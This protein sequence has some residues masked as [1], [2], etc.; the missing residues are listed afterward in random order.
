MFYPTAR[1]FPFMVTALL[2]LFLNAVCV[3]CGSA[4]PSTL[5]PTPTS[6]LPSPA[7]TTPSF[8]C[9]QPNLVSGKPTFAGLAYSPYHTGQDPTVRV[10]NSSTT[11]ISP[12]LQ[13]I[14]ADMPT[15]ASLTN[16]IRIYSSTGPA[17]MIIKAAQANHICVALGLSLSADRTANTAEIQAG[18]RLAVTYKDVVRAIIVGNEVLLR[19]ELQVQDLRDYIREIRSQIG[20]SVAITVADTYGQWLVHRDLAEDVDFIT[21]HIY[22][23][24]DSVSIDSA[25]QGLDQAYNQ[26]TM[27]F[28]RKQIIIGETGWPSAGSPH[29]NAVPSEANQARYLTDFMN[30]AQQKNILYFYFSA[31]DEDW[32]SHE[33]V[34]G[35]HWGLY[36]QNGMLKPDLLASLPA[37]APETIRER[38]YRDVYVGSG[39]EKP[40]NLG[41]NTSGGQT[42]WVTAEDGVLTLVYPAGQ[43]WGVVFIT[44]G[45]SVPLEQRNGDHALDLSAYGFLVFDMRGEVDRQCIEVGIKDWHQPDDGMEQ[46]V[47]ECLTTE[48]KTYTQDLSAFSRADRTHLYIVFEVAF[49]GATNITIQLKNIHYSPAG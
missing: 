7:P 31:F 41:V 45:T 15:L 34:V 6:H 36:E 4:A 9:D 18:E 1:R 16:Y 39:F 40:F 46:K 13:E 48:W 26:L 8:A 2:I 28:P 44:A 20:R 5:T 27:A 35:P 30:W 37:A 49:A 32:K 17:E 24:W 14:Q 43:Q 22:P 47:G 11:G 3:S 23:F 12:S 25:I 38:S 42:N 21:A 19:R 10:T 29:G 33:N